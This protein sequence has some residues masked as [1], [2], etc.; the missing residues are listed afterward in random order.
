M[1]NFNCYGASCGGCDCVQMSG[2]GL[3][4]R[5]QVMDERTTVRSRSPSRSVDT[6]SGD[7]DQPQDDD[8]GA[9]GCPP[10]PHV[11]CPPC[12]CPPKKKKKKRKDKCKPKKK[13]KKRC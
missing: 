6:L 1:M 13:K 2:E 8:G 11:F 7:D 4:S 10:I 5:W 9:C 12:P 3:L